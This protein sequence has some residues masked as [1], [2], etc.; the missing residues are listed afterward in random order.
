MSTKPGIY[1]KGF[2]LAMIMAIILHPNPEASGLSANADDLGFEIIKTHVGDV[3]TILA[4]DLDHDNNSDIIYSGLI[5]KVYIA[6]GMPGG[7]FGKPRE[8]L[9]LSGVVFAAGFLNG[10]TLLDIVAAGR[11][12]IYVLLNDGHREYSVNSIPVDY[13]LIRGVATG[14]I[15]DD[16]YLDIIA[17]PHH[18]LLG[19]G[20]GGFTEESAPEF[21]SV[22]VSDFN[23]DGIDDF[24][25]IAEKG[26]TRI[27][28]ND[29]A[30]NF[31]SKC[32][33]DLGGLTFGISSNDPFADFNHDGNADFAFVTP[34]V[35]EVC[36]SLVTVGYG[37]G[38]GGLLKTDTMRVYG[39]SYSLAISDVDRDNNL[40]LVV[41]DATNSTLEVFLGDGAGDFSDQFTLDYKTDSVMHAMATADMDR[42]GNPD[43]VAGAFWADSIIVAL[44]TLPDQYVLADP[45]VTTGYSNVS[46]SIVNPGGYSISR[47][48]RTVAGSVY[49]RLDANTDNLI[50]EQAVDFNLQYGRYRIII[51]RRPGITSEDTFTATLRIGENE[52]LLF[53]DYELPPLVS[54][55]TGGYISD[56]LIFDYMV[57]PVSSVEP[58]CG[59][60][61]E[62]L[63][64][65]FDWSRLAVHA[66]PLARYHFQLSPYHNFRTL[67]YSVFGLQEPRCTLPYP[68]D[69]GTVYYW[70]VRIEN[71]FSWPEYSPAFAVYVSPKTT[72]VDEPESERP[73]PD[74][75][76]LMQNYPN[77]F[78]S[79]TVIEYFVPTRSRVDL[80]IYNML[81]QKVKTL[82]DERKSRGRFVTDWDGTDTNGGH[83][84]AGIYIYQLKTDDRSM[85]RKMIYLK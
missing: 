75:F 6:Y 35:G 59:A 78:N 38:A 79:K 33:F 45:M 42:D 23:N 71:D 72:G 18:I 52:V 47:N 29:G 56:S 66:T 73:L 65:E 74:E 24:I 28:L 17:A 12:V 20:D 41:S 85:T 39:T 76:V 22:Y 51:K 64:P 34:H 2:F 77:P 8:Y 26:E 81:G 32:K 55:G 30:G 84:A 61:V 46:M 83:V 7:S 62:T 43:F 60:T 82:V 27:F 31:I 68:L 58:P 44:N 3:Q 5:D 67:L 21:R 11:G 53:K 40:D 25:T 14:Y 37:D 50:D 80:T 54:D 1:F 19:D 10:D 49:R 48:Y 36:N 63:K 70:R 15:N 4:A 9:P 13:C 69:S 57:E 16:A